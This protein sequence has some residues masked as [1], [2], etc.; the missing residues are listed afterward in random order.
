MLENRVNGV[1]RE[2]SLAIVSHVGFSDPAVVEIIGLAG[3]DGAFID[4]EH[5]GFDLQLMGE[6]I[7]VADLNNRLCQRGVRVFP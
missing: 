5:T 7:R 4:M 2:G 1:M 3:F 6:M